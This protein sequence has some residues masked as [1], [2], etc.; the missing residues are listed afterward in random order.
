MCPLTHFIFPRKQKITPHLPAITTIFS[1]W[2]AWWTPT[3]HLLNFT[4]TCTFLRWGTMFHAEACN[5]T[6]L[7]STILIHHFREIEREPPMCFCFCALGVLARKRWAIFLRRVYA[8]CAAFEHWIRRER[9]SPKAHFL[10]CARGI[11]TSVLVSGRDGGLV[12][13]TQKCMLEIRIN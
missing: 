8:F 6:A 3:P 1:L 4:S 2:L 7:L 5:T 11:V 12:S 13:G 10:F 9:E